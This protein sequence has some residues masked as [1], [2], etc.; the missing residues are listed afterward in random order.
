MQIKPFMQQAAMVFLYL[1][2]VSFPFSVAASNAALAA[3]LILTLLSG[4]LWHGLQLL[5]QHHTMLLTAWAIMLGLMLLSLTW[6]PDAKE[7]ISKIG[8]LW[9]VLLLPV[10]TSLLQE[11]KQRQ[12]FFLS[13]STGLTA[14]LAYCVVQASGLFNIVNIAAASSPDDPA[15]LI[16][17]IGFGF[18]YGL[19]AGWLLV[20]ALHRHGW[21]RWLPL[22]LSIWATIMVFIVQGRGGYMT[23]LVLLTVIIW[24]EFVH[25]R[26]ASRTPWFIV[27]GLLLLTAFAIG[28]GHERIQL[29]WQQLQHTFSGDLKDSEVRVPL[30]I[31]AFK[32]WQQKPIFGHGVGGYVQSRQEVLA[33]NPNLNAHEIPFLA[34]PHNIYL[35]AMVREGIIGLAA[36]LF[37]LSAWVYSGW[38]MDWTQGTSGYLIAA[39]GLAILV[40]GLTSSSLE[41]H[42]SGI[43]AIL[44]LGCGLAIA[45]GGKDKA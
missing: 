20:Q 27:G 39:P 21:Q 19:W 7:G 37:L 17:H 26:L 16:G 25:G 10:L 2:A 11:H 36:L 6:S 13:L 14:H 44:L 34:H 15:G 31:A 28:P 43:M 4:T 18:V 38:R 32:A 35:L 29:T 12:L 45:C 24:K 3:T 42:Y 23:V 33:E 40:N 30:W 8:H 1:A 9:F 41:E 5:R 22:L